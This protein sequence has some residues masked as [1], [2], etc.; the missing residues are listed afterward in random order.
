MADT[1]VRHGLDV[2]EPGAQAPAGAPERTAAD[3]GQPGRARAAAPA[4]LGVRHAPAGPRG[5]QL[6]VAPGHWRRRDLRVSWR[7][8]VRTGAD[9]CVGLRRTLLARSC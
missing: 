7:W 5:R 6:A 4:L 9:R 2:A 3:P 8:L 1:R